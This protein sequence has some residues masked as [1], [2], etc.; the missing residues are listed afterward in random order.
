MLRHALK[1]VWLLILAAGQYSIA[2]HVYIALTAEN[3]VAACLT[4]FYWR[5]APQST[6]ALTFQLAH[7][8]IQL[9]SD[10]VLLEEAFH[11]FELVQLWLLLQIGLPYRGHGVY[12][13]ELRP[14]GHDV[15]LLLVEAV[16]W[17]THVCVEVRWKFL[18]VL[19]RL[20]VH[21][22]SHD[23]ELFAEKV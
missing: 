14:G 16:F 18:D 6:L 20:Q 15:V 7:T 2:C 4:W 8:S 11:R 13:K 17:N 9:I 3:L 5:A 21:L 1:V 10:I 12:L 19:T 22:V 23:V